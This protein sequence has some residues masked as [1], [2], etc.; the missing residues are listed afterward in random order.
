MN[1]EQLVA[2]GIEESKVDGILKLYKESLD[3]QFVPKHRFDEANSEVKTIKEQIAERDKQIADLKKFEGDAQALGE[4]IKTL[5]TENA[6][7]SKQYET[8]LAQEKKRNTVKLALLADEV[9][10]PHDVDMVL[11]LLNLDNVKI[12]ESG[13]ITE[14]FK[15]QKETLK[16]E[17]GFLFDAKPNNP[18]PPSGFKFKGTPPADGDNGGQ[19][20]DAAVS[21]GKSLAAQKLGMLGVNLDGK[22]NK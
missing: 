19:P 14:G 4:K 22:E 17:K 21:F 8:A 10:K 2:L 1:K 5:E 6:N 12:D 16:K 15:E 3:G 9:D 18:N 20:A 11:S 7:K 13:K